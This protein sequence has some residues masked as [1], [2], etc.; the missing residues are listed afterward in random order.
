M[1]VPV[2]LASVG[3]ALGTST[4][5]AAKAPRD[6]CQV[7]TG[8]GAWRLPL[9]QEFTI[10]SRFGERFHPIDKVTKMHAGTDLV[11]RP[12]RGKVVAAAAGTVVRAGVYG[13]LGNAVVLRHPGG[14]TSTYG[15]LARI[16]A[17]VR[18]GEK[19]RIG[20]VLGLEGSTG[21]ST[22]DHLHFEIRVQGVP[23]DPVPFMRQHQAP[24][25]GDLAGDTAVAAGS[26]L[27]AAGMP[28]KHTVHTN[29][30]PVPAKTLRLYQQAAQAYDVPWTL[31]AGIGMEE[32]LHGRVDATSSAG[33]RGL[34]QFLP[35][36]WEL[37]GVDGDGDG[38]AEI[39][40]DADSIM[41]AANY[42]TRSGVRKGPAGVRRAL[43]A[44]N[45]ADW[46]VNDVLAYAQAYGGGT[47]S[48]VPGEAD[49]LSSEVPKQVE[50]TL[51]WAEQHV[52]D[53]HQLGAA[54]PR[55]WDAS[56]YVQRAYRQVRVYLPR[57]AAGQ[58]D[59]LADGHGTRVHPG[60]ERPGDL[61]FTD[62]YR[63]PK[64]VGDVALVLDP[65]EKTTLE[66]KDPASGVITGSYAETE[67]ESH[68]FEI[69]RPEVPRKHHR[70]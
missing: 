21:K 62:S 47:L 46:Y 24:L 33:A 10:S 42:L 30:M 52:G 5:S 44:Y 2:L 6:A 64:E 58:R 3:V 69:W 16:D 23:T 20:E 36:T 48:C 37:M 56:S 25:N 51:R 4:A 59:W 1:V 65:V 7:A 26:R 49:S 29:A 17:D 45:H 8:G 32:T 34:M 53:S 57:T 41:S 13:G 22:G 61:I 60:Q 54:G 38:K 70:R 43:F 68:I 28:R 66:A 31:L 14:V 12:G 18:P 40:N 35:S 15:H 39:D 11:S 27:P 55:T 50:P 63:G 67:T 19:V 9:T